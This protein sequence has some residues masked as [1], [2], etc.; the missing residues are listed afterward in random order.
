MT[1]QTDLPRRATRHRAAHRRRSTGAL[2]HTD[3]GNRRNRRRANRTLR[4]LIYAALTLLSLVFVLF[5]WATFTYVSVSRELEPDDPQ[6]VEE[7]HSELAPVEEIAEGDPTYVLIIGADRRPGQT[8]A[9]SDTLLVMRLDPDSHR[10]GM[11]S[12]PRDTRVR[13]DG[14]GTTKIN[15][16]HAYGGPALAVRTVRQFTGLP[17]HHFVEIDFVGFT[18]IVDSMGGV[19]IDVDRSIDDTAGSDTGGVSDVTFIPAGY[20][21]LSGAQALTYVRSRDFPEGDFARIRNQQRFLMAVT[22]Q[23]LTGSN[24]TRLPGTARSVAANVET[25]MSVSSLLRLA[26]KFRELDDEDIVGY[27]VPGRPRSIRGVSYVI[28]DESAAKRTI[29]AFRRGNDLN[30]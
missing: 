18:K 10:V 29:D 6:V 16:A 9:R 1:G 4:I 23:A 17:I 28:A 7:I 15:A 20:Q 13:I 30:Q 22:K 25:D 12:I 27:T 14:H 26:N 8:R 21:R 2:R 19:W 5:A 3:P 24:F 11:L